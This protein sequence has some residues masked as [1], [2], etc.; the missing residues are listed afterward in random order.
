MDVQ[1]QI[2]VYGDDE[3]LIRKSD[4]TANLIRLKN[5]SVYDRI[6]KKL[7]YEE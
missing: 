2:Y 6:R 5:S 1:R 7:F 3:I 4:R